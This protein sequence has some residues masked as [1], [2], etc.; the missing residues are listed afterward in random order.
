MLYKK[1]AADQAHHWQWNI[2]IPLSAYMERY[3][4][5]TEVVINRNGCPS[6]DENRILG[7][8]RSMLLL[9]LMSLAGCTAMVAGGGQQAGRYA[10]EDGRSLEQIDHDARITDQVRQRLASYPNLLISTYKGVVS[11]HGS[12]H[13]EADIQTI[14]HIVESVPGVRDVR[15]RLRLAQP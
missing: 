6:W 15:V 7:S 14:I 1:R 9:F 11:V 3:S 10:V 5:A 12:I 13:R 8:M 4:P 2:V